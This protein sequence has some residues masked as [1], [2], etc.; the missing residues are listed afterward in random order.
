[1][2]FSD[3]ALIAD[4]SLPYLFASYVIF[5]TT[6]IILDYREIKKLRSLL[7]YNPNAKDGDKDGKLQDG[8][9]W[10]RGIND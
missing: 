9:I 5:A 7:G 6:I 4:T 1:M 10:E 3:I 2:N 8:T